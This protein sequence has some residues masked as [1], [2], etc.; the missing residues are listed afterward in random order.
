MQFPV[1]LAQAKESR[2]YYAKTLPVLMRGL[3]E[4]AGTGVDVLCT[5]V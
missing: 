5:R 4:L 2:A 1:L 3:L